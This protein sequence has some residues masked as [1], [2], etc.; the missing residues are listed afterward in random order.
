MKKLILS[1]S[2]AM[3]LGLAA[4]AQAPNT[5]NYQAAIRTSSGSPLSSATVP[6]RFT[7]RDLTAT[8]T[9]IYQETSSAT[10]NAQGIINTA[11]GAG[12]PVSGTMAGINWSSG[13]KY[14]EVEVDAGAGLVSIGNQKMMSV[15][16]A[17]YAANAGGSPWT[18]SGTNAYNNN[19]GNVG[20]NTTTPIAKLHVKGSNEVIRNEFTGIGWQSF[21]NKTNYL[22]Y[23]GTWT[24]TAD[25]DFGTSGVGKNVNIVT[26]AT[27]KLTVK[28]DG[29]VGI[30]TATPST[31]TKMQV[32]GVGSSGGSAP[33][34]NNTLMAT[35]AA[36]TGT[37]N[38]GVYAEGNWRGIFGRNKG[39]VSRNTAIGVYGLVDSAK[40]YL[41][42]AYGVYGEVT[43]TGSAGSG[44][45]G[46]YGKAINGSGGN[47]SVYGANPGAGASDYAA[48][49]PGKIYAA[50]ASSSIKSFKI[51][52]SA[53]S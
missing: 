27:P 26:N 30:G 31:T 47:Y 49:F 21:Y 41:S 23:V 6:V 29:T 37:D 52:P 50:S 12:T 45:Y 40:T 32:I 25:L 36:A 2:V 34:Y 43:A 51:E 20:I 24:D 4:A 28:F 44:N 38:S 8:G 1:F 3:A 46:V 10:S 11:I 42:G 15:P 5:I 16:F 19:T 9:I 53:G 13:D 14:L 17:L 48:Y 22:G 35:S 33:I 39:S 7:V 18:I